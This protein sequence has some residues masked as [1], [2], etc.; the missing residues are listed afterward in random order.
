MLHRSNRTF[1]K[2]KR[3]ADIK[4]QLSKED[5]E[6]REVLK[7]E[8]ENIISTT[9]FFD[10]V[11]LPWREEFFQGVEHSEEGELIAEGYIESNFEALFHE[12]KELELEVIKG[13]KEAEITVYRDDIRESTLIDFQGS[14]QRIR[15]EDT[16]DLD[17]VCTLAKTEGSQYWFFSDKSVKTLDEV[18]CL[19]LGRAMHNEVMELYRKEAAMKAAVNSM[20]T[21]E[22]IEG[23]DIKAE[24]P[25]L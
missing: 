22:E 10:L 4:I 3:Y 19:E 21:A 5:I 23:Y 8:E 24:W 25:K 11:S 16:A 12:G 1:Q 13:A 7:D 17:S 14:K 15:K 20:Q 6:K 9:Y 18:K 2:I